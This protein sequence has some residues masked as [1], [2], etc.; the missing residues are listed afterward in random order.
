MNLN[1]RN[2][3]CFLTSFRKTL[4]AVALTAIV[5]ISICS[6]YV[7]CRER[8]WKRQ[9]MKLADE[10][11]SAQHEIS[12]YEMRRTYEGKEYEI[13]DM[14]ELIQCFQAHVYDNVNHLVYEGSTGG[15][16]YIIH[17]TGSI[18]HR[19]KVHEAPALKISRIPLHKTSLTLL[20]LDETG[21][22]L[23]PDVSTDK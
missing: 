2:S 10:L 17:Y 6:F 23:T 1:T 12:W 11:I 16:D 4:L 14:K 18:T 9:W 20:R 7:T 22:G 19:M 15:F 3:D 8:S 5:V 13:V 21:K